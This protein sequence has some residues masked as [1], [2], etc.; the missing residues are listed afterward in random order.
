MCLICC[1]AKDKWQL[2]TVLQQKLKKVYRE[3]QNKKFKFKFCLFVDI[4][5]SRVQQMLMGQGKT[6][7][8]GPLLTLLLADGEHL[9][10]HV[11]K[12]LF[13]L[14]NVNFFFHFFFR[15]CRL[16]Y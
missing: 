9:V 11:R 15:L 3:Q 8:V 4:G 6:T 2:L 13:F 10:V 5:G 7:V 14:K 16:L 1:C 12:I